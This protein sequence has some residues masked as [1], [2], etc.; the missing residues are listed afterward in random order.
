[1]RKMSD[2]D[3]NEFLITIRFVI[4]K[5]YILYKKYIEDFIL[6]LRGDIFI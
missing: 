4:D 6:F 3:G 1:M 2:E 5:N